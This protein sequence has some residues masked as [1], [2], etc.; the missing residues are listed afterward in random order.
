ML[1][2]GSVVA[3]KYWVERVLGR[4]G[5]GVV[6]AATHLQLGQRVALKFLRP[7]AARD[8]ELVERFLREARSACRLRGEHVGRVVDVGTLDDGLPYIVMEY[9]EGHDLATA[10]GRGG[11]LPVVTAVDY[12]LQ[13]CVGLA[14][15]H[16]AGL[17]HRD[18]KPANLFLTR[19]PDGT[20]LVKVMDF[21]IAKAIGRLDAAITESAAVMGS[22]GYM[23]PEQLRSARDVDAR[24]DLWSLGVVLY[25][26][27][28][29]RRPYDAQTITE[30]AMLVA[31]EPV[32][33][34]TA[35]VPRG[36]AA[37]V[38]RCLEKDP[39]RRIA[40][41][42]TL[43]TAL[44]PF[45]SPGAAAIAASV[46]RVRSGT[47]ALPRGEAIDALMN[48]TTLS[49]AT[50]VRVPAAASP[51]SFT[52]RHRRSIAV[53]ATAIAATAVAIVL[54]VARS[55][56]G[57]PSPA[58]APAVAPPAGEPLVAPLA[59]PPDAGVDGDATVTAAADVDAAPAPV[60][61]TDP[62]P[63]RAGSGRGSSGR[64]TGGGSS[65]GSAAPGAGSATARAGSAT[66]G[67]GTGSAAVIARPP[68]GGTAGSGSAGTARG[69]GSGSGGGTSAPVGIPGD[70]NGDGIPDIR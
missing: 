52:V 70:T 66:P 54:V 14:E 25:E 65:R 40:D 41:V 43:A 29:G 58:A 31:T 50:S 48:A 42:A 46:G 45:G 20:P 37:V 30:L 61:A 16:A 68:G 11:P 21:G 47:P 26:L 22:P 12:L 59:V 32:P 15:A 33:P 24:A 62:E 19:R 3:E 69:S 60:A 64:R 55:G 53:L 10:L 51:G 34:L 2:P 63:P 6:V 9:L 4:G 23:S 49:R 57:A 17:V 56:S 39:A 7:E 67:P 38:M 35:P 27:V 5:M 1:E 28:S 18:L 8:S 13:A 44:A 36:F